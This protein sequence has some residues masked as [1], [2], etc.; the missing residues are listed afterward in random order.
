MARDNDELPDEI[1]LDLSGPAADNDGPTGNSIH[2]S[3]PWV[4]AGADIQPKALRTSEINTYDGG[5][6]V[7]V[8]GVWVVMK[9]GDQGDAEAV[10][11]ALRRWIRRR[12]SGHIW[13][14]VDLL[15]G[16]LLDR[17]HVL[18]KYLQDV[19]SN[20]SPAP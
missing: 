12:Q 14:M 17:S 20:I 5:R 8:D 2:F 1:R 3:M 7:L 18:V 4:K 10:R 19:L 15:K 9:S 11:E 6:L 13:P 16:Y